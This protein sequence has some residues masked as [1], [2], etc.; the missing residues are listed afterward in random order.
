MQTWIKVAPPN[1]LD[2]EKHYFIAV[3]RG[4]DNQPSSYHFWSRCLN[5]AKMFTSKP[6]IALRYSGDDNLRKILAGDARLVAIE[7]PP[8]AA[9]RWRARKPNA[10]RMKRI[11]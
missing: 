2:P 3:G 9:Q 4:P 6:G 10:S 7:V 1:T 8:D 5:N 11:L